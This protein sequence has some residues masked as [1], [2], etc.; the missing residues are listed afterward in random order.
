MCRMSYVRITIE[1]EEADPFV[2]TNP[3]IFSTLIIVAEEPTRSEATNTI[4]CLIARLNHRY[5][6]CSPLRSSW[7]SSSTNLTMIS[8]RTFREGNYCSKRER[9]RGTKRRIMSSASNLLLPNK[10]SLSF[11]FC[12]YVNFIASSI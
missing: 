10:R 8:R 6:Y 4:A 1:D 3:P 9:K 7:A 11:R 5:Y 12:L 2:A